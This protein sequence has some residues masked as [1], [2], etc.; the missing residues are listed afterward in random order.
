MKKL[1]ELVTKEDFLIEAKEI[2]E[3]LTHRLCIFRE[4]ETIPDSK[5]VGNSTVY[6]HLARARHCLRMAGIEGDDL[7]I[8]ILQGGQTQ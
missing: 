8:T 6:G 5:Y 3:D 7:N 2:I 4:G 1:N